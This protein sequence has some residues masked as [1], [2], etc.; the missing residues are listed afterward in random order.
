MIEQLADAIG[1]ARRT[2]VLTG[3][4]MS[5]ES[6]LPDYRG[7]SGLWRNR[8]FEELASLALWRLEPAAFWAFYAERLAGLRGAT[9]N[10]GHRALA[11]LEHAG[12]V[13][14]VVTQNVDGLHRAAGT[15]ALFEAHGTLAEV[16][17]LVC[18]LRAGAEL[19]ERQLVSGS[20][21]P[22]CPDC[23][24]V[25]KPAVVLFGENL[26]AGYEDAALEAL[27]CDLFV[28]LGSSLAVHPVAMLPE[29]AIRAGATLAIVNVGETELDDRAGI[30]IEGRTGDVLPE[31]ARALGV[32]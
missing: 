32:G 20:N 2:T 26:P 29:Y 14:Y 7:T 9:P 30:R 5:T 24:A 1:A 22:Q 19:A 4:G 15:S 6:G 13:G 8:R 12:H 17:C 27:D 25:L 28:C 21:V 10:A 18:G 11:A 31:L 16:E 3:A 23:A